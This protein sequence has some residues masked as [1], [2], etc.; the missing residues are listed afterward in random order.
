MKIFS[1]LSVAFACLLLTSC[2]TPK[3]ESDAPEF[4]DL[5]DYEK[6]TI[7]DLF[8]HVEV[9]PLLFEQDTYPRN[10]SDLECTGDRVYIQDTDTY[11]HIFSA[12]T[13]HYISC[14]KSKYGNGPGEFVI[15]TGFVVNPF[16]NKYGI[17]TYH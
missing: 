1:L 17:M 12:T 11:I 5:S 2:S 6:G 9:V 3:A 15:M 13:G 10:V 4:Y 14:S 16:S 8:D 7:N